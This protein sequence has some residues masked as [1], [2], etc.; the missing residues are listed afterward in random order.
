[1]SC[2]NKEALT[3]RSVLNQILELHNT[4]IF[5]CYLIQCNFMF[6][7]YLSCQKVIHSIANPRIV[8]LPNGSNEINDVQVWV[9]KREFRSSFVAI[10][11]IGIAQHTNIYLIC[12]R[13]LITKVVQV[14][15]RVGV[16]GV[17]RNLGRKQQVV[18]A[19]LYKQVVSKHNQL[20]LYASKCPG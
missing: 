9:N 14:L 3:E 19:V 17:A 6:Y 15:V 7:I 1:M 2:I 12:F 18:V 13:F 4:T 20:N 5:L 11:V 16:T 10:L 8:V